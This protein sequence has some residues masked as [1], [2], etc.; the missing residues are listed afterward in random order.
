M[1]SL[2]EVNFLETDPQFYLDEQLS[3][4][5]EVAGRK[6]AVSDPVHLLFRSIAYTRT[7][8]AIRVNDALKQQLLRYSRGA[9]LDHKGSG[10]DTPRIGGDKATTT[11]RFNLE[12]NRA[13]VAFIKKGTAITPSGDLLFITTKDAVAS[14]REAHIDV[15]AECEVVGEIGNGFEP[16]EIA[17]LI[18]PIRYVKNCANTTRSSGGTEIESDEAYK[19]R[20]QAAPEKMTTAGS[21]EAYKFY[22]FRAS[23]LI[24]DV[25]PYMPEP[26]RVNVRFLL[27][28][29]VLPDEEMISRVEKELSHK[30][31]RPLTDHLTVSAPEKIDYNI[32]GTFF[33]AKSTPNIDG[34]QVKVNQAIQD[35]IVWQNEVMARDIN[36]S[37]LIEMCV[38]AGAKRIELTS[39]SF[40]VVNRGQVAKVNNV[41]LT[42]GGVEDD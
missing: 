34:T 39:P 12:E 19:K 6:L 23:P 38:S 33:I 40:T 27:K 30:K 31:V 7:K 11:I 36:P 37:K 10:W 14:E 24:T 42:F 35:F 8:H 16:G 15:Q 20:I 26:G 1:E 25:D 17:E 18:E 5:E 32:D 3:D 41:N 2:P 22:T 9:V 4:Y 28:D 13:G 29:G 21:E